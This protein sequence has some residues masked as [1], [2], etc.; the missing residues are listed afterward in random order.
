M[1]GFENAGIIFISLVS[2][3]ELKILH[4]NYFLVFFFFFMI[5]GEHKSCLSNSRGGVCSKKGINISTMVIIIISKDKVV[6]TYYFYF[7]R[8][9]NFFR[10]K[11]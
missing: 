5:P 2:V 10:L 1:A 9:N 11:S 8:C 3:N 7:H 6:N 4:Y